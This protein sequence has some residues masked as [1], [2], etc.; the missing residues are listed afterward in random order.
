[1]GHIRRAGTR[2]TGAAPAGPHPKAADAPAADPIATKRLP[3][4]PIGICT[5]ESTTQ[6]DPMS[7]RIGSTAPDFGS[8]TTEGRIHFHD[9]IGDSRA[10]LLSH[11]RDLRTLP[12]SPSL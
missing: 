1:V 3:H 5:M 7:L 2:N 10:L 12:S 4:N 8:D 9:W 6:G 11:P